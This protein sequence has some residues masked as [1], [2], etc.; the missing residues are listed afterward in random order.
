MRVV[1]VDDQKLVRQGFRLILAVEPD[2]TV[3]GEATNGAEGVDVVKETAP[4]VVLMDVQM[5]VMDGVAATAKIREFSDVKVVILTTFDRDDYLFDA[6]RAGAS[7]FLLKDAPPEEL[8]AAIRTVHRGD[9]VIAP[10]TTRRL[11]AHMVPR[12]RSDHARTAECEHEQAAVESLTPREREVLQLMAEGKAN[13]AIASALHVS[14]GSAEKHI[15][16]IFAKL[17]VRDRTRAVLK[18]FELQL[19]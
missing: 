5:P 4:D 17:G 10:S 14:V 9:A 8:L 2:I 6:L 15:A 18:A 1:L 12:L 13:S 7:G 3:V 19:V 11:M 16:S